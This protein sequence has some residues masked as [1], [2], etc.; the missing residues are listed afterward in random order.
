MYITGVYLKLG[1]VMRTIEEFTG[2]LQSDM[3]ILLHFSNML[4]INFLKSVNSLRCLRNH[5]V[6]PHNA[7]K[8]I[9]KFKNKVQEKII[10]S[11]KAPLI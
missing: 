4:F 8:C 1:M 2:I 7:E 3:Q 6:E 9:S 11:A 5:F 10:R